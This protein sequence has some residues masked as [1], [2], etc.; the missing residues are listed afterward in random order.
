MAHDVAATRF[1]IIMQ[2]FIAGLITL[3]FA[4]DLLLMYA[5]WELVGLCSF[6]LVGFWYTDKAAASGARKVLRDDAQRGLRAPCRDPDALRPHRHHAVDRPAGRQGLHRRRVRPDARLR[7]GEVGAVPAAHLDP[8]GHGRPDAGQRPAARGRATSRP[9]STWSPG[10][11]RFAPWPSSWQAAVVWLGT[12]TMLVGVAVRDGPARRQA[13]AG[14]QHRQPDR[15][16]DARPRP[17]HAARR[18]RG[19]AAHASTTAC[20]RAAC[21]SAPVPSSTP[22]G[23]GTWTSSAGSARGCPRP[24]PLWLISAASIAG[25]A[26]VQRVRQQV[27]A[28]RGRPAS[29]LHRARADRL[30]RQ[31]AHHVLVHEGQLRACSSATDGE[32]SDKAHESPRVMLIGSGILA[33]GCV[34]LGIAPQLA[35]DYLI[36]PAAH[37]HGA[38]GPTSASS[39]FGFSSTGGAF[40]AG[41]LLMATL[42][43]IGGAVAYRTVPRPRGDAGD[44]LGDGDLVPPGAGF[45]GPVRGRPAGGR[46]GVPAGRSHH[47]L[48]RRRTVDGARLRS[49]QRLLRPRRN[50]SGPLLPLGRRR[51]LLP[52]DLARHAAGQRRARPGQRLAG[53]PR[54][55]RPHHPGRSRRPDRRWVRRGGP[56]RR[57]R[58]RR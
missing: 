41:G 42:S 26:A 29:G 11:T 13:A 34:V 6:V 12:V 27:A 49:G 37:R 58:S 40:V 28:V 15:L 31:R 36:D 55:H 38:A 50:R 18:G 45:R 52:D 30:D 51:P 43:V 32:A 44:G 24:P 9:A 57:D 7:R 25:R 54:D 20:S 33:A 16:H 1:Y 56:T 4:A 14:L 48:H 47:P 2:V 21:S 3:V 35:L 53:A 10:C 39:W 19:P 17:R 23:P 5:G 46:A 8:L 22:P